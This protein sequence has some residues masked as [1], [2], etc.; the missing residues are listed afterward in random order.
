MPVRHWPSLSGARLLILLGMVLGTVPAQAQTASDTGLTTVSDNFN[1]T[2]GSLG[3]NWTTMTGTLAPQIVGDLAT[4]PSAEQGSLHSA[5]WSG[6]TFS[7]DQ[8][9][10]ARLPNSSPGT[11]FGPGL[12]VRAAN[13][14][15][16]LLW[17]GNSVNQVTIWRMDSAG[18]WS[19]LAASSDSLTITPTTDVWRLEASGST[20]SGYQN[21]TLVVQAT[22]VT[23]ADGSPGVWM[24]YGGNQIDDWSAGDLSYSPPPSSYAVGGTVSGLA[25]TLVLQ[26]TG[27]TESIST[28]GAFNFPVLD[29][30]RYSITVFRQPTAQNC[31]IQNGS[32]L[33]AGANVT[34]ISVTCVTEQ[35]VTSASDNFNRTDGSLGANWTAMTDAPMTISSQNVVGSGGGYSGEIRTGEAF[36]SNQFSQITIPA[37]LSGVQWIG[38]V[39]RAQNGGQDLYTGIYWNNNGSP[40]MA[41]YKR[42][43][44]NWENLANIASGPLAPGTTLKLEVVGST[45]A[46]LANGME[47]ATAYDPDGLVGG[48]PGIID[49]G[50]ATAGKWSGGTQGFEAH[51]LSIDADGVETYDMIS[52]NDGYGPH[53]LR[54]LR[55]T[56]AA[57]GMAHNF[58]YALPVEQEGGIA[59]G[60]GLDTL[61]A[62]DAA[63]QYN[64]TIIAPS[65][66]IPPWFA[67]SSNDLNLQ[68]ETFMASELQPWA[69]ANLATTGIEQHWLIGFSKSGLGT[70]DLLLKHPDLFTLGAA[71]D[72]P[73]DMSTY[74]DYGADAS[75]GTDANFQS[76]YRLTAAF[77]D[78]HKTPFLTQNRIWIGGY[79]VFQGNIEDFDTLLT[80]KG[81]VHTTAPEVQRTH[82]WNTGWVP[83]ALAGLHQESVALPPPLP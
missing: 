71:W 18:A 6:N 67:D 13:S 44:G 1:R 4:V 32:G 58:V 38:P 15:G 24:Y 2:D 3:A 21:G 55:P 39:V 46:L 33:V 9:V 74:T 50:N 45:L 36:D 65:F 81:M 17:Y 19:Q 10:Q 63:N 40:M 42:V 73:A 82:A 26:N 28:N 70:V 56:N 48:A 41:I 78:A 79:A 43:G 23:Y 7:N 80:L 22:D 34:N 27:N 52:A 59:Y 57:A 25:G 49:Y 20:L 61:R 54:V 16:Y 31:V 14:R 30:A 75:Y 11:Y 12:M 66:A 47:L 76:N 53:T 83:D 64:L 35:T 62:L 8:F 68:Y 5:F 29:G 37:A 77:L 60:D 69:R 51:Y 72:F